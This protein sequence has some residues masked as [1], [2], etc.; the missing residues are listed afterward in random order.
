MEVRGGYL[1]FSILG[2]MASRYASISN[3]PT[4]RVDDSTSSFG[5]KIV[6][7]F[8]PPFPI[9]EEK[10]VSPV[11]HRRGLHDRK[12]KKRKKERKVIHAGGPVHLHTPRVRRLI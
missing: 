2:I 5:K 6:N 4:G 8:F 10:L 12:K 3:C 9:R 7:L 1:F 11:S